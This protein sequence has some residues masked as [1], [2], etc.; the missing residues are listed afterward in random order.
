MSWSVDMRCLY[1]DGKLP[2]YRK[3]THGQFCSTAHRKA[4]WLEQE[5]LAVERLHQTHNSLRAYRSPVPPETILGPSDPTATALGGFVAEILAPRWSDVASIVVAEAP[6]FEIDCRPEGPALAVP[7]NQARNIDAAALVALSGTLTAQDCLPRPRVAD[8]GRRDVAIHPC[9]PSAAFE[10]SLVVPAAK[11]LQLVGTRLWAAPVTPPRIVTLSA[12]PPRMP[13]PTL[14]WPLTPLAPQQPAE[15]LLE[16][17]VPFSS[18]LFRLPRVRWSEIRMAGP[19][20]IAAP[21]DLARAALLL[22]LDVAPLEG[23]VPFF[24]RLLSLSQVPSREIRM[25]APVGI[26]VPEWTVPP[27]HLLR[28]D[29]A[30]VD[31]KVPFFSRLLSLPQVPSREI[32]KASPVGIGAPVGVVPPA[33]HLQRDMAPQPVNTLSGAGLLA[34]EM[35]QVPLVHGTLVV[36]RKI[37]NLGGAQ[38]GI[39]SEALQSAITTPPFF[40]QLKMAEGRRYAV[41]FRGSQMRSPLPEPSDR[42]ASPA[43]ITL[44][45]AAGTV[46]EDF[47]PESAGRVPFRFRDQVPAS[48]PAL[49]AISSLSGIPQ[50]LRSE[51]VRPSSKLEPLDIKPVSDLTKPELTKPEPP[52]A[53]LGFSGMGLPLP[54]QAPVAKTPVWAHAAGFWK[55]APRDLKLLMFAIPALL[56]LA[57]HPALPK[58]AV[59]APPATGELKRSITTVVSGQLKNVRQVVDERAAVALDEDF[60][61]GLDDWASRGDATA[62]MVFR[63]HRLCKARSPGALPPVH[64]SDRLSSAVPGHDR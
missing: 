62:R 49:P 19:A 10:G 23:K 34:L 58:V 53:S 28:L 55:H 21:L 60:R 12:L 33:L 8:L 5:Q 44:P 1:C 64:G 47:V 54:E 51:P 41:E 63:R 57:F 37:E 15:R 59:A 31:G 20:G 14:H 7:A 27:A 61:S 9:W 22:R 25:A 43:G 13:R 46:H 17:E 3:I 24:S 39:A 18:R 29:V 36:E 11:L 6:T 45:Q 52:A 56:A 30:P 35:P 2:L 50:P 48:K 26:G 42:M 40:P 4:Y 16:D 32:R 38:R